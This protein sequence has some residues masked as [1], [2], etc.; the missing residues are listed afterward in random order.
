M[1]Y[2]KFAIVHLLCSAYLFANLVR[3][4]IVCVLAQTTMTQY[5]SS[6]PQRHQRRLSTVYLDGLS[7]LN[8]IHVTLSG[9]TEQQQHNIHVLMRAFLTP[10]VLL[11]SGCQRTRNAGYI[12]KSMVNADGIMPSH[13]LNSSDNVI[14]RQVR[15]VS[16]CSSIGLFRSINYYIIKTKL[17]SFSRSCKRHRSK[18]ANITILFAN[19]KHQSKLPHLYQSQ[20]CHKSS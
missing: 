10:A 17:E 19:S 18:T 14:L 5:N 1:K 20:A 15:G 3:C 13:G 2:I 7:I 16:K 12:M 6:V 11:L 9:G 4:F 8:H